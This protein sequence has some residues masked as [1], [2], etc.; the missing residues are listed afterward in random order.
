MKHA[1]FDDV[2]MKF[3]HFRQHCV[4]YKLDTEA[5]YPRTISSSSSS[6]TDTTTHNTTYIIIQIESK[7][8]SV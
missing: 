2:L 4:E 5:M 7:L 8:I 1:K 3:P 6:S